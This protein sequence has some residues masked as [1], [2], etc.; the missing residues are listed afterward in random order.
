M[1]GGMCTPCSTAAC[2]KQDVIWTGH[3]ILG[4]LSLAVCLVVCSV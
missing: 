4:R 2:C 1:D 3:D